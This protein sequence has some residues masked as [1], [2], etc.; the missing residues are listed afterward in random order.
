MPQAT[1]SSRDS[2]KLTPFLMM[3]KYLL[4][5]QMTAQKTHL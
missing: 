3:V 1:S 2:I 4:E 5:N